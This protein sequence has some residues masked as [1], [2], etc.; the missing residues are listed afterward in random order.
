MLRGTDIETNN[1]SGFGFKLGISRG[2]IAL[3]AMGAEVSAFPDPGYH[4]VIDTQLLGQLSGAPV[5]RSVRRCLTGSG[6][7]TRLQLRRLF[8][9]GST[10]VPGIQPGEPLLGKPL[11][12]TAAV[13][14]VATPLLA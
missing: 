14:A 13:T 12:P 4:H 8:F 2:H 5:G 3:Q 7:N 9:N 10:W 1:I 11:F 6:Q